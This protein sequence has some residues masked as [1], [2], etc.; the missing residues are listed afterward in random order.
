MDIRF[1][2]AAAGIAF[3]DI[4]LSGDNALVI[5][6]AASRLPRTRRLVAIAWGGIG[7]VV[8]RIALTIAAT[9]VL[10]VPLLQAIGGVTLLVIAVRVLPD[11]EDDRGRFRPASDRFFVAVL[12]ILVADATMSLDNI[13][14]VGALAAGNI[15]LLTAGL[16]FSMVVLFVASAFIVRLMDMV[17]LLIDLAAIVIAFTAA[18]LFVSDPIVQRRLAMPELAKVGIQVGSVLFIVLVDLWRRR[19]RGRA[20]ARSA[21]PVAPSDTVPP[22][23]DARDTAMLNGS[24]PLGEW[25]SD[26]EPHGPIPDV[27]SLPDRE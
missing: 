18:N 21:A 4:V 10:R 22:A 13:L 12:T 6:A 14:A 16:V 15:A 5:A 26:G 9:E 19:G 17:P 24:A 3:L 25:A 1:I 7:A 23:R 2:V 8:F 20:A 11:G 27:A